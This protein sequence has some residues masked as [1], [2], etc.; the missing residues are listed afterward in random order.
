M[1]RSGGN[2]CVVCRLL[3]G[4]EVL[5]RCK[6]RAHQAGD[7]SGK[8]ECRLHLGMMYLGTGGNLKEDLVNVG[9]PRGMDEEQMRNTEREVLVKGA[10]NV[11]T[12]VVMRRAIP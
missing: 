9:K 8:K 12:D 11:D 6:S 3:S 5:R 10:G 1:W 7:G 2:T 4:L